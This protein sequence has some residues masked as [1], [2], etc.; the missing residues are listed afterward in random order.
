MEDKLYDLILSKG[1]TWEGLIKDIVKEEKMNPWNIDIIKLT[2]K[3][4]EAIE[5]LKE[6]DLRLSGKFL[7]TAAIL[8][9][10]K[11]D[12]LMIEGVQ[13]DTSINLSFIF[14]D[15][16]F[17]NEKGIISYNKNQLIPRIPQTKKRPVTLNE[18]LDALNKA[19]VVK[20]RRKTKKITRI[21]EARRLENIKRVDINQKIADVY[22]RVISFFRKIKKEEITFKQ[23][24]PSEE[25]DD[26]IWTFVPLLQLENDNKVRLRQEEPFG[27]I[28]VR[29]N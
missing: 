24:I 7:L 10:M 16:D 17:F 19:I 27:E 2:N 22:S 21:Q 28:Y 25:R 20:D 12:F 4:V 15:Y 14:K 23:L 6:I 8:L 3:Y 9:K 11:S 13:D 1:L 5:K 29:K 26:I 18:L